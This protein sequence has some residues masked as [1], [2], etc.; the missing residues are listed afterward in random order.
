[1]LLDVLCLVDA[2]IQCPLYTMKCMLISQLCPKSGSVHSIVRKGEQCDIRHIW[3]LELFRS[4]QSD[5]D[6]GAD[7]CFYCVIINYRTQENL[8]SGRFSEWQECSNTFAPQFIFFSLKK[9][10]YLCCRCVSGPGRVFVFLI[11]IF[12]ISKS[13]V[14][15]FFVCPKWADQ[16]GGLGTLF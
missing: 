15:V 11:V 8:C 6:S 12:R 14:F 10:K 9:I 4:G 3:T 7:I 5:F 13:Y 1:M 2:L 16:T